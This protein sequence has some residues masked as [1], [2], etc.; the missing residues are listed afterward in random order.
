MLLSDCH[1]LLL[2]E[3][4][5]PKHSFDIAD[6]LSDQTEQFDY[7]FTPASRSEDC[8]AGRSSEVLAF[9]WKRHL[10]PFIEIVPYTDRIH[11]LHPKCNGKSFL[12]LNVYCDYRTIDSKLMY[13]SVMAD[14]RN[15]CCELRHDYDELIVSGDWNADPTK[16][17]FYRVMSDVI[18]LHPDSHTYV[19]CNASCA[20]SWIDHVLA[21][22][23][24]C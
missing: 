14:L 22:D 3:T 24:N 11:G 7:S 18:H 8:F 10:A 9:V 15:I 4:L 21:T 13:Q 5:L 1:I 17:R 20:T 16:G 23:P 6:S 2:Q 19:S 12:L